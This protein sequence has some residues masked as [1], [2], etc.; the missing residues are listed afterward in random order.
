MFIYPNL[1]E[2]LLNRGKGVTPE[3][4]QERKQRAETVKLM[5]TKKT[6]LR[7]RPVMGHR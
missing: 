5:E 4:A 2:P 1:V 7:R 6:D 3:V